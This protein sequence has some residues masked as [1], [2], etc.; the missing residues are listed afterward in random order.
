MSS[1]LRDLFY[2]DN[3]LTF[4]N[5]GSFG[6]TPKPI[7]AAYHDFQIEMERSPVQFITNKGLTCL[8]Q[9]REALGSYIGCDK[10]DVVMVTNPSYAVNTVARSLDLNAGD[11]I[12][13]TDIEYGACDKTW[14]FIC[15]K[16]GAKYIRQHIT[17]PIT[18]KDNFLS[19]LLAGVT[20]RTKL[21]FISH[22]TSST[23]LRLP[24]EEICAFGKENGIPVFVDGAH[25]PGQIPLD[26]TTLNVDYY[27]GACHKWMMAPKGCS[28]LYTKR[29]HQDGLDPLV[30]SWGYKALFPSHSRYLDYHQMNG[31]RDYTAFLCIPPSIAFMEEQNWTQISA[32]CRKMV[33]DNA[34]RLCAILDT[35]PILPIGGDFG[36]QM[37][38]A[39]VNTEQPE[40][41]YRRLV[42]HYKIEIPVMRQGSDVY[43]RYSINAFNMQSELDRLFEVVREIR[44]EGI[45]IK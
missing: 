8:A 29:E 27:T 17:L 34:N 33:N 10:D 25:V 35:E 16:T 14:D 21:I 28:F 7:M 4:L 3:E 39:R 15:S 23:A 32:D 45:Y 42:D 38:A 44:E 20:H 13:T 40:Q 9:S 18:N 30:V 6:A 43:L 37:F 2:L 26:L 24:V 36:T 1:R 12:L 31:T 11:E 22:I 19:N 5:F 41:L